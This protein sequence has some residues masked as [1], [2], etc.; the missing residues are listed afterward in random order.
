MIKLPEFEKAFEYE[1]NFYLSS[2]IQRLVKPIAHYE[3]YKKTINI[4]GAFVELGVFKGASFVRF[5]AYREMLETSNSRKFIGFDV[6]GEFPGATLE[7]DKTMLEKYTSN[8]GNLSISKEQLMEVIEKKGVFRN[9]ELIQ[10]DITQTIPAYLK[11]NTGIRFSL[12][13]LDVD[14]YEPS[15]TCLEYMYPLLS[16]GGILMLDDY[17]IW[18]GETRAVDEYFR[19]N[20]IK[21]QRLPFAAAPSFIVKD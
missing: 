1:N 14:L 19:E 9:V 16:K 8:A 11:Q 4:P 10:G 5:L 20:K 6:F 7:G 2:D 12:I 3:L 13:H 18:E 21:I 15:L 17:G